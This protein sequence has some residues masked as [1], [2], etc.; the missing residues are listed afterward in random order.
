[1]GRLDTSLEAAG[2]EFLVLGTLLTN[3]ILSFKAYSNFP[4]YD[5][6]ATNPEANVTC[7]IQVKSRWATD[8]NRT[9]LM[10]NF[11]CDF[12]VLVALNRGYR[13]LS[14]RAIKDGS[15]KP[16]QYYVFPVQVAQDAR[17]PSSGWG[18]ISLRLIANLGMYEDNWGQVQDF[19]R[20]N[21]G[22]L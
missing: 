3:G 5:I 21:H 12:V 13:S 18:R 7:L 11:D 2:A 16:P 22:S 4:G 6:V 10:R 19:L 20:L 17:D 9:F 1:M 8:Y 15:Q 14:K